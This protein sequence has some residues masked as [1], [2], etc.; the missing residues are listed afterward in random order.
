MPFV[1]QEPIEQQNAEMITIGMLMDAEQAAGRNL[2]RTIIIGNSM[3]AA[4]RLLLA[5]GAVDEQH[6][7]DLYRD[8]WL[9][10]VRDG[11]GM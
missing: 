4:A 10:L 3:L 9:P 11:V 8:L 5:R 2:D 1:H 7:S 6:R